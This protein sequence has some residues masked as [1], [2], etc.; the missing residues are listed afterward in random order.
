MP[1]QRA[2]TFDASM[3]TQP[4]AE[5]RKHVADARMRTRVQEYQKHMLA[6]VY[7]ANVCASTYN[8]LN[9]TLHTNI[10]DCHGWTEKRTTVQ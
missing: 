5:I 2:G 6:V 1:T 3:A 8:A 9:Q 7:A 4:G 10:P